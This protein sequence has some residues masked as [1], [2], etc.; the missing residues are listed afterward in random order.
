[1]PA[2]LP[3]V[4]QIGFDSYDWIASTIARSGSRVLLWVIGA[5][6]TPA[7][8]SG[9]IRSSAF[10]FPI[11]GRYAGGTVMLSSPSVPAH[12]QLRPRAAA[13]VQH[14]RHA[15]PGPA[16]S[17]PVSRCTPRPCARSVPHYGAEL[18]FTGHLQP[19]RRARGERHFLIGGP[20]AG[21]AACPPSGVRVGTVS[22]RAPDGRACRRASS[23]TPPRPGLP[24]ARA[25]SRRSSSR[26]RAA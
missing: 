5:C 19:E 10:S 8:S 16:A 25:T 3:S 7:A 1:M 4:N 17:G 24:L 9:S 14:P 20:T 18:M 22:T 6:G 13:P 23:A 11:A 12:V 15:R 21:A 2:F 26:D